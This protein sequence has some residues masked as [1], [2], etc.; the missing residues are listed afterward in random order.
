MKTK[1]FLPFLMMLLMM[2]VFGFTTTLSDGFYTIS[3]TVRDARNN[4]PLSYA[5]MYIP[6]TYLGTVA[7]SDGFFT[8]KV[9]DDVTASNFVISYMGYELGIFSIR[10]HSGKSSD[11]VLKPHVVALQEVTFRP[12]NPR[13]LVLRALQKVSTNY[14]QQPYNMT[15]FYRETIRQRREYISVAEAV[16]DIYKEP[17]NSRSGDD[18]VRILRGRKSGSVKQADTL[19]VKL[20][21][22]PQVAMLLDIVKYNQIVISENTI[23]WYD[24]TLDE[25]VIMDDKPQYVIG[26][27]PRV[28]LAFPIFEGKLYIC[29]QSMAVT[30]AEFSYDLTD[31]DLVAREFVRK[32]PA[33]LRFSPNSTRYLVKYQQI[34]NEHFVSYI[35]SDLEFFVNWRR[36]LFRNRYNLMF[37]MAIMDRNSDNVESFARRETFR[38]NNILT[39]MV[40]VYFSDNFWGDYNF[41]EPDVSI[42]EAILKLNRNLP[43]KE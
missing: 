1:I 6:G 27:K 7:N 20:Q 28:K 41:I 40:P 5:T 12:A 4:R 14:P 32:K 24:Y 26:F 36:K 17:Y 23:D 29:N 25:V 35:R 13:D 9:K 42:E 37:E 31:K 8:F 43:N 10:E 3:G 21:G 33:N 15:G 22:G 38:S 39:D 18:Q 30:M 2:P 11:F 19:L 16:I 34:G